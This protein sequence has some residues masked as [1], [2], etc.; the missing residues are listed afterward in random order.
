MGQKS[1]W[2]SPF[3]LW[4]P[5][6]RSCMRRLE[7][8]RVSRW[9]TGSLSSGDDMQL[10]NL[11]AGITVAA[12]SAAALVSGAQASTYDTAVEAQNPLA[13][14]NFVNSTATQSTSAVNGYPIQLENGAAVTSG[15]G[16]TI[17][18][19]SVAALTLSN[20]SGG[21]EY[22]TSNSSGLNGGIS[23][24]GTILA[25][26]NLASLPSTDG[27]IFSIAGESAY[28]D[29]VDLQINNANDQLEF[30]TDSGGNTGAATN[31]S[32]S[33]LSKWIFVAASFTADTDRNIYIDGQLSATS[34]PGGHSDSG[35]PFYIGQSNVFG[36]RY[37]DGSIAD[38]AVY[39]SDLSAAQI[40]AIYASASAP[41]S[42]PISAAPEPSI[43]LLM[44]AGI[45]G[46]GLMLRR[47][48]ST[49]GFRFKDAL[50]A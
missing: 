4:T 42:S 32:S 40:G 33:D 43:W 49:M 9:R 36:N 13:Y 41:G 6:P 28:G 12:L 14:Y 15:A 50:S 44:F 34:V 31:F 19:S 10:G 25:W 30:F 7:G 29:D 45:G 21:S 2:H 46:I 8:V 3:A 48:K 27:R 47:A 24:A 1:G 20:G 39:N 37:F 17:N 26:I 5:N 11:F 35:A 23:D 38:V 18:G 16:P 22:A